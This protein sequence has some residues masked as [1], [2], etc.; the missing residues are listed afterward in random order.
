MGALM[1]GD[2]PA[3]DGIGAG[4]RPGQGQRGRGQPVLSTC[5]AWLVDGK[6]GMENAL[7]ANP[8]DVR[9]QYERQ[10]SRKPAAKRCWSCA[11]EKIEV[12][13]GPVP[14]ERRR[15]TLQQNAALRVARPVPLARPRADPGVRQAV[16]VALQP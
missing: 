5:Q 2:S 8:Q 10:N 11:P 9:E 13:A 6:K 14:A 3:Q 15:G 7:K 12:T 4:D 16:E 1:E